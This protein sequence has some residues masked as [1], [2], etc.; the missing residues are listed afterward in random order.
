MNHR[1]MEKYFYDD[2][3]IP[4]HENLEAL[5]EYCRGHTKGVPLAD[6]NHGVPSTYGLTLIIQHIL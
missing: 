3:I 5:G 1:Q 4:N 2:S 6:I